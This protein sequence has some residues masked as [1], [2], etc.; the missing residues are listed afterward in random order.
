[1]LEN[2]IKGKMK[3]PRENIFEFSVKLKYFGGTLNFICALRTTGC[4]N[5][6]NVSLMLLLA[7][8]CYVSN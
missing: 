3:K 2:P 7:F 4:F 1:M 6:Q 8:A 5:I